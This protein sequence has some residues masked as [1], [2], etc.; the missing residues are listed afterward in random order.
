MSWHELFLLQ[1]GFGHCFITIKEKTKTATLTCGTPC[2]QRRMCSLPC[3]F[4]GFWFRFSIQNRFVKMWKSIVSSKMMLELFSFY[5]KAW[6]S[7]LPNWI[8]I[9]EAHSMSYMNPCS[10]FLGLFV[11]F[12]CSIKRSGAT[13]N[14]ETRNIYLAS[15]ENA[16]KPLCFLN[17]EHF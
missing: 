9:Q 13:W 5:Q 10:Q 15:S 12:L 14:M 17:F 16:S 8:L 1:V 4:M 6:F 2:C 7:F 11:C 3:V